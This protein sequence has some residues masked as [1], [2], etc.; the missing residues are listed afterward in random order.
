MKVNDLVNEIRRQTFCEVVDELWKHDD[1]ITKLLD[2]GFNVLETAYGERFT[3]LYEKR[4]ALRAKSRVLV[5][6]ITIIQKLQYSE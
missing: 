2:N 3:K 5:D 6:A 4:K 1:A